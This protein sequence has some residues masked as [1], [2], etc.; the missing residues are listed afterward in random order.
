MAD[1]YT[2]L[3]RV[4]GKVTSKTNTKTGATASYSIMTDESVDGLGK[5]V[6]SGV[7][8]ANVGTGAMHERLGGAEREVTAALSAFGV[9]ADTAFLVSA[10]DLKVGGV[11]YPPTPHD[12]FTLDDETDGTVHYVKQIIPVTTFGGAYVLVTSA[13]RHSHAG[14]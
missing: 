1:I 7:P 8:V 4:A 3:A 6:I 12:F 9:S 10:D 2:K 11:K 14:G 13:N 5:Q